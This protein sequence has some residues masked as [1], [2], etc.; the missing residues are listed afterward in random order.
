[1]KK[2]FFDPEILNPEVSI[3]SACP[4]CQGLI[5]IKLKDDDLCL[6]KR[7][8]P[9]CGIEIYESEIIEAA[10]KNIVI[11]QAV[12][13]A[14]KIASFDMAVLVFL[15][16]SILVFLFNQFFLTVLFI[17]LTLAV[18]TVPFVFCIGWVYKHGKWLLNDE[19][20][21][22]AKSEI[23]KSGL[24]WSAAHVL[25]ALLIIFRIYY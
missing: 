21:L 2:S 5:P 8:C 17:T 4:T 12:S 3:F 15:G 18:W 22:I 9:H 25:N 6:E 20:Y 23:K 7:V 14:N 10:G 13:S 24:L 1:M 19:D 11:T 16:V